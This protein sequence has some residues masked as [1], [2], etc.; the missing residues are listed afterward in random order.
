MSTESSKTTT[1]AEAN[2]DW[3]PSKTGVPAFEIF[4]DDWHIKIYANGMMEGDPPGTGISN[5]LG[6]ALLKHAPEL[7][8]YFSKPMASSRSLANNST[9]PGASSLGGSQSSEAGNP[10]ALKSPLHREAATGDK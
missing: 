5:L 6:G 1:W 8:R 2:P 9:S 4:N 7:F 3:T 10:A